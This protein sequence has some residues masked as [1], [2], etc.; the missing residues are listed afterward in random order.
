MRKYTLVSSVFQT[1]NY[2]RNEN[3]IQFVNEKILLW[4]KDFEKPTSPLYFDYIVVS[5]KV[6]LDLKNINC[7]Q[8]IIDSSVPKYNWEYIKNE[9]HKYDIHFYNVSTQGAYLLEIKI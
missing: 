4:D 3:F 6:K 9:C 8:V 5:D 2:F 7:K 1:N